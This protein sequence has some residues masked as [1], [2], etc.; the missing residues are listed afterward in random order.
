M[1]NP[2]YREKLRGILESEIVRTQAD[3]ERLAPN[4]KP[5][6]PDKGLGRITRMEVISD[7]ARNEAAMHGLET[8]LSAF[9]DAFAHIDDDDFGLCKTCK[10]EIPFE[11]L[12]AVPGSRFCV[13]CA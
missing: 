4:C 6:A 5:V 8:Q 7:K 1:I 10:K 12:K 13:S 9:E 3:I 2:Y 11:R